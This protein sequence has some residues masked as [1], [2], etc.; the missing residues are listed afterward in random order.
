MYMCR[1]CTWLK[2]CLEKS[3]KDQDIDDMVSTNEKNLI[4]GIEPIREFCCVVH[5]VSA[6]ILTKPYSFVG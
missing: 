6:A 1:E 5:A 2:S 3:C 4:L